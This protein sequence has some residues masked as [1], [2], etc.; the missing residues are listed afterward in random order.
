MEDSKGTRDP[1]LPWQ[2][3]RS[4]ASYPSVRGHH[5]T[6]IGKPQTGSDYPNLHLAAGQSPVHAVTHTFV[7]YE[8]VPLDFAP[9]HQEGGESGWLRQGYRCFSCRKI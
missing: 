1:P 7:G 6:P 4:R 8:S 3:H 9:R 2:G 5:L